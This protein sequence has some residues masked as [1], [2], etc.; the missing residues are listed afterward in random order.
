MRL[1]SKFSLFVPISFEPVS[2]ITNYSV[3][4]FTTWLSRESHQRSS[5]KIC[6][7]GRY[8]KVG[9]GLSGWNRNKDS[10]YKDE[11]KERDHV[12]AGCP[13]LPALCGRAIW[14]KG[15]KKSG[16]QSG[17]AELRFLWHSLYSLDSHLYPPLPNQGKSNIPLF[18][19][20]GHTS[21]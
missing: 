7:E 20:P 14:Y 10:W 19:T 13:P 2:V 5:G 17:T 12:I 1:W 3:R 9:E 11:V 18:S 4:V 16:R 6:W 8:V 21:D 15:G